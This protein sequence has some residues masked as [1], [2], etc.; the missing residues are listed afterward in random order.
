MTQAS[1]L[2]D[3]PAPP[4]AQTLGA[5]ILDADPEAGTLRVAF[6]G[7]PEFLNPAGSVQG[8]FLAAMLDD[9]MGPAVVVKSGGEF[10]PATIDLNISY[11]AP[12][13]AGTLVGE[14]R[15]VQLGKTVAFLEGRLT[16]A[17]GVVVARATASVRVVPAARAVAGG[18]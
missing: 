6:E 14:G 7:R 18:R 16:D 11:L 12:A 17:D 2:D 13:K 3:F 5:R 8:G 9:C 10:Y 1:A 4:C 15:V